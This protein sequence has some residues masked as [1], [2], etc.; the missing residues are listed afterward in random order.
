MPIIDSHVHVWT[1]DPAF[2]W[3]TEAIA[4]PRDEAD[5]QTLLESMQNESVAA[6]VL[7]QY[8][9]YRWDN[10]YVAQALKAFPEKFMGVCRVNPEDPAAPDQLSDWTEQ[11]GFHGVRISPE[12]D[13]RGDWFRGPLMRPFFQ[14]AADLKIPVLL[15]TKPTRLPDLIE[16]LEAV[17]DV[18]VVI[19]HMADCNVHDG[20]HQQWLSTLAGHPRVFLK[21]GH[22]WVNSATGYPWRD[23]HALLKVV[24]ALFGVE[25]IMWG[26]D[27]SFCLRRATY[28]QSIAYLRDEIDFL[29]QTE[30]AWV[31]GGTA[32]RLWPFP[33]I[34]P[35]GDEL[36][37]KQLGQ[38]DTTE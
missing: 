7:V 30:L 32:L 22:V 15:L 37:K 13:I 12:P 16:I 20:S 11:H 9:G 3:A 2:P 34:F 4:P 33:L 21:T 36:Q 8:I 5:P 10:R 24:C 29:S 1:N 28:A 6:A 35:P 23:Q 31:L 26:S 18:D 14:R 27:W 19:D 25:R 17:P 38:I